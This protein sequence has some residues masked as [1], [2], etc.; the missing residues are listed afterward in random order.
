[1]ADLSVDG[2]VARVYIADARHWREDA[3]VLSSLPAY[4][5]KIGRR[6]ANRGVKYLY[7]LAQIR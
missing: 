4:I 6:A 7:A 5:K 2:D 1:M 3:G